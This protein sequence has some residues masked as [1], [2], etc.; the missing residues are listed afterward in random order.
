MACV[1]APTLNHWRYRDDFV[2]EEFFFDD[3]VIS[4]FDGKQRDVDVDAIVK[5]VREEIEAEEEA[6]AAL[7]AEEQNS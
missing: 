6:E 1:V 7:A 2:R 3:D 4:W 5:K